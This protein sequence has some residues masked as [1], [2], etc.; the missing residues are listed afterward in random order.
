MARL[1]STCPDYSGE[2][3]SSFLLADV[4]CGRALHLVLDL[5]EPYLLG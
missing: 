3:T 1:L 2:V 5:K 4:R